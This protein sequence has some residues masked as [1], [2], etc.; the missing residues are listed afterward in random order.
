MSNQTAATLHETIVAI[1]T[2]DNCQHSTRP[3]SPPP[4]PPPKPLGLGGHQP[5]TAFNLG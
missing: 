2:G 4:P 1:A 3:P 5:T